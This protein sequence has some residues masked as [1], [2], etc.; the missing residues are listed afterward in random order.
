MVVILGYF[1]FGQD[2]RFND[3]AAVFKATENATKWL[4]EKGYTNVIVEV[5]NECDIVYTQKI[6]LAPEIHRLINFI[7]SSDIN[8]NGLLVGTSFSGGVIP[9]DNVMECSD[10]I[11][12]HGNGVGDPER[13]EEMVKIIRTK[14]SYKGQP[15]VFNEDDHFD[16]ERETNNMVKS[17]MNGA[18]WGYFDPGIGNYEDGYQ[19]PPV[20]WG[21][22]TK[23][24]K[25]FFD[26][27][28]KVSGIG[29]NN[30]L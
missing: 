12:V 1:Y 30:A 19:C 2:S 16:F 26:L 3:E 4:N 22:N 17:L 29:N 28:R 21:I 6:L 24:K 9:T 11:I 8:R 14:H 27:V 5:A 7:K 13:I 15:I 23:R 18:S 10:F 20:N 25:E